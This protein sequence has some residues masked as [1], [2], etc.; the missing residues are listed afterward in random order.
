MAHTHCMTPEQGH[1]QG[2]GPRMMGFLHYAF[3]VHTTEGQGQGTGPGN[4]EFN[5]YFTGSA[6]GPG[7]V[8]CV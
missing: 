6:S 8:Q 2:L 4:N 7:P 3:T 5:T 1:G